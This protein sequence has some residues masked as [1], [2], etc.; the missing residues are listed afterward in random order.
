MSSST[1]LVYSSGVRRLVI[2]TIFVEK[3]N[4]FC[5]GQR[6]NKEIESLTL[7]S[8]GLSKDWHVFARLSDHQ[9]RL[10]YF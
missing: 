3:G 1:T 4:L 5:K 7:W 10:N 6:T 9:P 8:I 2:L